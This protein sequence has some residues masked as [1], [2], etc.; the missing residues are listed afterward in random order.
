MKKLV[1]HTP[2]PFRRE[3]MIY[4]QN[5]KKEI[6]RK[7]APGSVVNRFPVVLDEG[8]TIIWITD[9]SKESEVRERYAS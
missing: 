6:R 3:S 1:F 2:K 4:S 9:R 8:R 5:R 7:E